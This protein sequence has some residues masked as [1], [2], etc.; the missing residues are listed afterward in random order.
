M[1]QRSTR[2]GAVAVWR[3][4]MMLRINSLRHIAVARDSVS[5][6]R[7]TRALSA[8]SSASLID[9]FFKYAKHDKIIFTITSSHR[10]DVISNMEE[11]F[12]RR[13]D[14]I[15]YLHDVPSSVI[16]PHTRL[17]SWPVHACHPTAKSC[18]A[19]VQQLIERQRLPFDRYVA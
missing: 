1:R 12:S 5:T 17:H 13:Y 7:A 16:Q 10:D 8:L 11:I 2:S 18:H 9:N 15:K 14:D 19:R 3:A 6:A 4:A